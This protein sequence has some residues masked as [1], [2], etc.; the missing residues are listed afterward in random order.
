LEKR[1]NPKGLKRFFGLVYEKAIKQKE[2]NMGG[3]NN[4]PL[5]FT[6]PSQPVTG[7]Q[8][9]F[10][11]QSADPANT[12]QVEIFVNGQR[13]KTCNDAV[14]LY[15]APSFQNAGQIRYG[16]KAVDK[17]GNEAWTGWLDLR[18]K[19]VDQTP[20]RLSVSHR[21]L[22]PTTEQR[23][24]FSDRATDP[25]GIAR[26]ELLVNGQLINVSTGESFTHTG[27][28][29]PKGTITYGANA[30]DT[31]GNKAWAEGK[32]LVVVPAQPAG[33][34]T[35]SGRLTGK[36]QQAA[37]GVQ[38]YS[39]DQP[40]LY[41]LGQADTSGNYRVA[42]LPNGRYQVSPAPRGKFEVIAE[43]KSLTITCQG[44]GTYT[45]NFNVKGIMEG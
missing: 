25:S 24:T 4:T 45:A 22:Q 1:E 6:V 16:A 43:P 40:N 19:A 15:L 27:G 18:I 11:A 39:L 23:I 2:T 17:W 36:W 12:V 9:A 31:A 42:N 21:P 29:Y 13:V 34:A 7:Q 35:V 5:I 30:Y 37:K 33:S 26:I 44:Q 3:G 28:P 14:C 10:V 8:V 20:P 41:F 32:A 38:V